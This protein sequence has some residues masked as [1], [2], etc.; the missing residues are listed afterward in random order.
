[1]DGDT[2]GIWGGQRPLLGQV[3]VNTQVR[4]RVSNQPANVKYGGLRMS[5]DELGTQRICD[6][7]IW[8]NSA[9]LGC[10]GNI[11]SEC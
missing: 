1:M 11:D 8:E 2:V 3:V 5:G 9:G 4:R 6:G 7:S 10:A